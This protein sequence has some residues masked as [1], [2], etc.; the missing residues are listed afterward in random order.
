MLHLEVFLMQ[1]QHFKHFCR[2]KRKRLEKMKATQRF[3]EEFQKDRAMRKKR[4]HE[5]MQEENRKIMEFASMWKQREDDRM[6]KVHQ[7]EE[8]KRKLTE[9]V[10]NRS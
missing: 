3:I 2:A 8:R 9:S 4:Q 7:D 5:E 6:A 1:Y 10:L